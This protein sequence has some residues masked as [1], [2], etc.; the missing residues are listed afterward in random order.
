MSVSNTQSALSQ[1]N[2]ICHHNNTLCFPHNECKVMNYGL[3]FWGNSPKAKHKLLLQKGLSELYSCNHTGISKTKKPLFVEATQT[4]PALFNLESG[5]IVK[6][7]QKEFQRNQHIHGYKKMTCANYKLRKAQSTLNTFVAKYKTT[8]I[9]SL[10]V[11]QT[12]CSLTT[13]CL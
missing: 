2:T 10:K 9:N 13:N 7:R 8:F 3:V 6:R 4:L 5:L 12:Y 1:D 11:K